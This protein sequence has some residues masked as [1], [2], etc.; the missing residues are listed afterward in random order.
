MRKEPL[1][2]LIKLKSG[3]FLPATQMAES[4][5]YTVW[6][7][8]GISGFHDEYKFENPQIVIGRVGAYCGC[9]HVSPPKSWITDNALYLSE[10][11]SDLTF[12][13]LVHALI[14]A[15][16]NRY[17][18]QFG[19]PLVSGSRIYPVQ[20]LV[21][22]KNLQLEFAARVS[23]AASLRQATTAHLA[24]STLCSHRSNTKLFGGS[25]D[26]ARRVYWSMVRD[27]AR[28]LGTVERRGERPG[29]YL[30]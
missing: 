29:G 21:P 6:G 18:S 3:D 8:N 22:P 26:H 23:S 4:G 12:D 11:S 15:G 14:Y 7:G 25:S 19:Q 27:L 10:R 5:P 16:L 2:D 24:T 17:A 9:V 30:L 20:I 28:D 1:G 13:Y